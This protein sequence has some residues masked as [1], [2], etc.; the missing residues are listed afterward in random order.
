M[1][2]VRRIPLGRVLVLLV[3]VLRV[4]DGLVFLKRL[5]AVARRRVDF[6]GAGLGRPELDLVGLYRGVRVQFVHSHQR[7]RV[8]LRVHADV[9]YGRS[10][11]WFVGS[12]VALVS[13]E[14]LLASELSGTNATGVAVEALLE[15]LYY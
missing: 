12:S 5:P 13:D 3:S 4:A 9:E 1:I 11:V 6:L 8:R 14:V 2:I 10:P 7:R 15:K